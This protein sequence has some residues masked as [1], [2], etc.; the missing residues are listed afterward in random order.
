MI[1][2]WTPGRSWV[3]VFIT[4]HGEKPNTTGK[5]D[6]V[7]RIELENFGVNFEIKTINLKFKWRLLAFIEEFQQYEI[8]KYYNSYLSCYILNVCLYDYCSTHLWKYPDLK[9]H[10]AAAPMTFRKRKTAN[11]AQ[12]AEHVPAKTQGVRIWNDLLF[13]LTYL[14]FSF[15]FHIKMNLTVFKHH[16]TSVPK[17][18][19]NVPVLTSSDAQK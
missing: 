7:C 2:T 4:M 1:I 14:A 11:E 6:I 17:T 19:K 9:N 16:A 12:A 5:N 15:I 13:S 10:Q 8:L 3:T 18:F